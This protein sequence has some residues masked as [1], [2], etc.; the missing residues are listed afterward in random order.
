MWPHGGNAEP[1]PYARSGV[2][3]NQ[4]FRQTLDITSAAVRLGLDVL[5]SGA[6]LLAGAPDPTP[7][8]D[9]LNSAMRGGDLNH[10][11]GRF[12]DG[13][14]AAGWYERD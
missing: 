5:R 14:D 11:T 7:R 8:E 9:A 13:T 3:M 4:I 12:D 2:H 10:R 6:A 1:I